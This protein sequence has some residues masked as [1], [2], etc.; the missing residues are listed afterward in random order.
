MTSK[1]NAELKKMQKLITANRNTAL[2]T[3]YKIMTSA[4]KEETRLQAAKIYL[5]AMA[6]EQKRLDAI[7]G[8]KDGL[9]DLDLDIPDIATMF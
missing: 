5:D 3:V 8:T 4:T 9:F 7:A 1:Q 2:E 6:Q